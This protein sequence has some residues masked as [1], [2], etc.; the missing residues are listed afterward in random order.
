MKKFCT[1]LMVVGTLPVIFALSSMASAATYEAPALTHIHVDSGGVVHIK[2]AGSPRPGPCGG[3]NFG[4]VVI[5]PT[6]NEAMKAL[7]LSIYFGGKPARID[8]SGCSG[9]YEIVV[10]LYSPSG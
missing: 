8:T 2:W 4:W 7:A 1:T 5:P 9:T 10:S 6:A 3:E